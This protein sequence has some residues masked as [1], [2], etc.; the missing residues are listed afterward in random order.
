MLVVQDPYALSREVEKHSKNDEI[1]GLVPTMGSLHE[2]HL[3]LIKAS[4]EQSH[5]T[6][7]SIFVNPLQFNKKE[8]LDAYPRNLEEDLKLLEAQGVDAVFN[9]PESTLYKSRPKVS[10]DFGELDKVLEGEYRPGHFKGVGIVVSKLFNLVKPDKAFFGLKDLQQYLI[11]KQLTRDLSY[12]IEIVGVPTA[13]EKSGLALSS[14]NSRLS[15]HGQ[16]IASGIYKGLKHAEGLIKKGVTPPEIKESSIEF[17]K[18]ISGLEIE[19]FEIVEDQGLSAIETF[20][21]LES[22]AVCVAAYVEGIRLI[23]NLYLRLQG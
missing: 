2:G 5:F 8:D 4:L 12:D 10:F 20:D 11:I 17:Y 23:D 1:I 22:V 19:Y 7:V 15:D 13:R 14:R 21:G 9:P 18:T 3:G 16:H 6:V